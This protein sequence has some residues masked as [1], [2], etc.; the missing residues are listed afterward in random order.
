MSV[1]VPALYRCTLLYVLATRGF[2]EFPPED[3]DWLQGDFE[4]AL[5]GPA[6]GG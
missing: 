4:D 5:L 1:E 2:G 6:T 3:R